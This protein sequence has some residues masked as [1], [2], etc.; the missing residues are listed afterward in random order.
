MTRRFLIAA[1]F[2]LLA[3]TCA[4]AIRFERTETYRLP[5]GESQADELWLI[6]D[7]ADSAGVYEDDFFGLVGTTSTL[8]G[9]YRNDLWILGDEIVM[10][11]DAEEHARFMGR[12]LRVSGTVGKSLAAA[13][14]SVSIHSEG[15]V[16][17]DAV[18]FGEN[19]LI[20]GEIGGGAR[21]MA[22]SVTV[23]GR[24][25]GN[26]RVVADDI[27][28]LPG[29]YIGGDV[30]YTSSRELVLDD[31]VT[32]GGQLRRKDVEATD[33]T[34]QRSS[35]TQTFTL[36]AF[37]YLCAIVAALPFVGIFPQF[38]G[39]AVRKLRQ[40]AWKCGL[41]GIAAF[42]LLPMIAFFAFITIIGIPL[43]LILMTVYLLFIYLSK[44]IVALVIGGIAMSRRG[45]Q[46]FSRVFAALSM[47]LL[48]LYLL[49]ALPYIGFM[50]W[51]LT[52]LFGLGALVLAVFTSQT[53][54]VADLSH[55]PPPPPVPKGPG[56]EESLSS[57]Q[58]KSNESTGNQT[59]E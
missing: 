44:V 55:L 53:H 35:I 13:A 10:S 49:G 6:A 25:H 47:G 11:G 20:E 2:L 29:A 51:I 1:G 16:K 15:V 33:V 31:K 8:S 7:S 12:V 26:L 5:E 34:Q 58:Q 18:L 14:S 54:V 22:V 23:T 38:T 30:V 9:V 40:S 4:S 32:V 41:V 57:D 21:I 43:S 28:I 24:I 39:T 42:C 48:L 52:T 59:K 27:V 45:P 17:G 36:Q 46:P 19:V 50:V 3:C 37:L 56:Q